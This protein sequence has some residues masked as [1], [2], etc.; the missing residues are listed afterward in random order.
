MNRIKSAVLS[1]SAKALVV[2]LMVAALL[3]ATAGLVAAQSSTVVSGCYDQ[4]TGVLRYLLSGSCA[5]KENPISWNQVGPQGPPGPQGE[6]G[7]PGSQGPQGE[8]GLQGPKGAKGDPGVSGY[9]VVKKELQIPPRTLEWGSASCPNG[10]YALGGGAGL[11]N[12]YHDSP[13]EMKGS[14]PFQV[15]VTGDRPGGWE[16]TAYNHDF[17]NSHV[18]EV[19]VICAN[20]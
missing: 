18:L 11:P 1:S 12:G 7:D 20:V 14:V 17:V 2:V 3:V 19:Y 9:T 4:K 16:G 10:Q 6:K 15:Q 5:S 13:L 8:Q